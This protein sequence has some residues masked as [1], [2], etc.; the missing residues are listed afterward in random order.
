MAIFNNSA[1]LATFRTRTRA[2]LF[3]IASASAIVT[4]L[5]LVG[6]PAAHASAYG[7]ASYGPLLTIK[8]V[9]VSKGL[10]CVSLNGS[11]T[12]VDSVYGAAQVNNPALGWTCNW[13]ITAEFFDSRGRW[14]RT[15]NGPYHSGC[16]GAGGVGGSPDR[17][18]VRANMQSGSMCSTLKSNGTR[19]TSVCHSIHP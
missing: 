6:A 1:N 5:S 11:G 3:A 10:Y 4:A 17:I 16:F 2:R 9:G 12:Y 14:Y 19:L 7:C 8:G 13:N 15:M 18:Y